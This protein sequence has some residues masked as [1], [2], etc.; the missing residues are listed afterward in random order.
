MK[1]QTESTKETPWRVFCS[2]D[3]PQEVRG[4]VEEH[5][6]QLKRAVPEAKAS[7][8]RPENIHLT[9]KFLG[10][11]P[12]KRAEQLSQ[13]AS[14]AVTGLGRFRIRLEQT[15]SFPKHG[16]PRVLWI[17]IRNLDGKLAE[18]F[19][20]LE[21]E[22]ATEGFRKESRPF[23]PH[24]TVARLRDPQGARTVALAHQELGFGPAEFDVSELLVMRSELGPHGS[25][26][27]VISRHALDESQ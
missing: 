3:I 5:I 14:R 25:K 26:Y 16:P 19:A 2:I 8:S 4:K 9:I 27:S 11:V 12:P 18:L 17:G 1:H 24:L 13:A 10:E 7:W 6:S 15:G 20:R 23:R 21:D 22:C